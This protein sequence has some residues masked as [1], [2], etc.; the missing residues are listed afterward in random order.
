MEKIKPC[1]TDAWKARAAHWKAQ[2][3]EVQAAYQTWAASKSDKD[4]ATFHSLMDRHIRRNAYYCERRFRFIEREDIEGELWLLLAETLHR[5]GGSIDNICPYL[6]GA[7]KGSLSH[8][9][10]NLASTRLGVN[11]SPSNRRLY[12]ETLNLGYWD[13]DYTKLMIVTGAL[14]VKKMSV[15]RF[16]KLHTAMSLI[17]SPVS[18]E[19]RTYET[20]ATS[21]FGASSDDDSEA[22]RARLEPLLATLTEDELCVINYRFG[23]N[24]YPELA[25]QETCDATGFAA[26]KVQTL[27]A[28]AM[29]KMLAAGSSESK[30]NRQV[31]F[32]YKIGCGKPGHPAEYDKRT[33]AGYGRCSFCAREYMRKALSNPEKR[34]ERA[35]VER[36]RYRRKQAERQA[37]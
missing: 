28:S 5:Y 12:F 27:W 18:L 21:V 6:F 32:G 31:R 35:R 11:V 22:A 16:D 1:D 4:Y 25:E 7:A 24:G 36:E 19:A 34:A 10:Y 9:L 3:A 17:I 29:K 26:R 37:A 23:I 33:K 20:Q 15:E 14:K 8:R 13:A 2:D 30:P